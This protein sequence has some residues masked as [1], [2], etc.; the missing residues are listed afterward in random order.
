LFC[1]AAAFNA[2]NAA[3]RSSKQD[4]GFGEMRPDLN[5]VVDRPYLRSGIRDYLQK[6]DADLMRLEP[7]FGFVHV[8]PGLCEARSGGFDVLFFQALP[9]RREQALGGFELP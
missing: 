7:G 9:W 8:A 6:T 3:Y 2:G 5:E 1:V 4:A